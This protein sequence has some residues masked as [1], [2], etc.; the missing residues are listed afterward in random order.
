MNRIIKVSG[1]SAIDS[2]K[3]FIGQ[4]FTSQIFFASW[5]PRN[6]LQLARYR[7]RPLTRQLTTPNRRLGCQRRG[8]ILG[9]DFRHP[10]LNVSGVARV[11]NNF[12]NHNLAMGRA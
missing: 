3:W 2:D 10:S 9:Q 11:N 4:V 1:I 8:F 5:L 7:A 12:P 6:P